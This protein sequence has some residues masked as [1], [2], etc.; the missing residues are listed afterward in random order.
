MATEFMYRRSTV[1]GIWLLLIAG[2][3][4]LFI[5]EP[6]RTGFF[7]VCVFR[8]LTGLTCPGCGTTRALHAILHGEL[9]TA[10]MLN[11]L[12]LLASP[13]LVYAFMRYSVTVMRG[14]VP[15][16]NAVPAPYLYALFFVLMG[17]W[18]FRN[19]PFYPFAS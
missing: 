3:V 17:F 15:R 9:E 19:T 2:A 6:G 10:F 14:G 16:K 5:F 8:L 13:L 18:I 1:A 12:L 11:P 4:Y 7:P